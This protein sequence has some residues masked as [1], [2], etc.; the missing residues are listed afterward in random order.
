MS[1][2]DE[3][4]RSWILATR[5]DP[6]GTRNQTLRLIEHSRDPD[7]ITRGDRGEEREQGVVDVIGF[8]TW[9]HHPYR[10]SSL[11]SQSLYFT[12]GEATP[13]VPEGGTVPAHGDST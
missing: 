4:I 6:K 5:S 11:G 13:V 7:V 10:L 2:G 1:N 12:H 3:K 8:P 9:L